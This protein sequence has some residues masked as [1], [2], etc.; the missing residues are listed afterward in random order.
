MK[1]RAPQEDTQ[2]KRK[3]FGVNVHN[4]LTF[5]PHILEIV[6]KPNACALWSEVLSFWTQN[7]SRF[8]T[9]QLLA[10][11]WNMRY[12]FGLSAKFNYK[13]SREYNAEQQN[14]LH[15]WQDFLTLSGWEK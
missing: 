4:D 3:T 12:R 8:Y 11:T 13:R 9:K 7:S 15:G 1:L 10:H 5:E 14:T 6:K 2:Q